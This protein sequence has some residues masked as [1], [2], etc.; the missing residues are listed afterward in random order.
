MWADIYVLAPERSSQ[1]IER[2]QKE[3]LG[4]ME[5][6]AADYW[7]PQFAQ[8]ATQVFESADELIEQL[9]LNPTEPYAIYWTPSPKAEPD[10][11]VKAGMMFFTEDDGLIVGLS[12][13]SDSCYVNEVAGSMPPD[14]TT[15]FL[16]RLARTADGKFGYVAVEQPPADTKDE[17]I[18]EARNSAF[19]K[20]LDGLIIEN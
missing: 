1:M 15:T 12:V 4:E 2:F 13:Q 5:E 6:S 14:N 10:A 3:W 18:C 20:L 19:A 9:L 7:F 11:E 17:F 16:E 8:Q